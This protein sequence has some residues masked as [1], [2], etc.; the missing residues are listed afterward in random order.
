MSD[1]R[2]A[3][4]RRNRYEFLNND[5]SGGKIFH[6]GSQKT[7]V[8]RAGNL[9]QF[10]SHREELFDK[11]EHKVRY[12]VYVS[13]EAQLV[14]YK[15][16]FFDEVGTYWDSPIKGEIWEKHKMIHQQKARTER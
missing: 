16:L 10:E 2:V 9:K 3:Q 7:V 1:I 5:L 4:T 14:G 13:S 11:W 15:S 6:D 8:V 12:M